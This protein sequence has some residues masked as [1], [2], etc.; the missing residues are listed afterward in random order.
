MTEH[1]KLVMQQLLI[2]LRMMLQA[3]T[4]S[5]LVRRHPEQRTAQHTEEHILR[6][7]FSASGTIT[8]AHLDEGLYTAQGYATVTYQRPLKLPCTYYDGS[9]YVVIVQIHEL[10]QVITEHPSVMLHDKHVII[11]SQRLIEFRTAAQF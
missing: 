9:T 10:I 11:T 4:C 1:R 3:E 5:H 2:L 8:A 7:I 6:M